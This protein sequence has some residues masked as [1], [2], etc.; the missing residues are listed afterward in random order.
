MNQNVQV[1]RVDREGRVESGSVCFEYSDGRQD[2]NGLFIRG[3]NAFGLALSIQTV[4]AAF[5]EFSKDKPLPLDLY[6]ALKDVAGFAD[7]IHGDVIV[8]GTSPN[9]AQ[10]VGDHQ[11]DRKIMEAGV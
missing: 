7:L 5:K 8:G 2:W 1:L 10:K 11:I 9:L 4:V 6:L 3:D